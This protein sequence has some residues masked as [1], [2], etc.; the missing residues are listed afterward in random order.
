MSSEPPE[1]RWP[2]IY[3]ATTMAVI[4]SLSLIGLCFFTFYVESLRTFKAVFNPFTL[5]LV[6]M[7]IGNIGTF[8]YAI[9][10]CV[11]LLCETLCEYSYLQYSW[12]RSESIVDQI[13]PTIHPSL[14]RLFVFH[15]VALSK[16]SHKEMKRLTKIQSL[17]RP[18]GSYTSK[19][20]GESRRGSVVQ[21]AAL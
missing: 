21:P 19:G 20:S 7:I 6:L 1:T 10:T 5:H 14:W 17:A 9:A 3:F 2:L 11:K 18:T 13:F 8:A 15:E 16:K 12:L 4:S